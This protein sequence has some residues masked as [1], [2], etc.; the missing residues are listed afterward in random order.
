MNTNAIPFQPDAN[1]NA[2]PVAEPIV[3]PVQV[4]PSSKEWSPT[5]LSVPI[6]RVT[7]DALLLI[8]GTTVG[9]SLGH[10]LQRTQSFE[11]SSERLLIGSL[12]YTGIVL[13]F[14]Q[15]DNAYPRVCSLLHVK[16]TETVLRV[17]IKAIMVGLL[18]CIAARYPVPRMAMLG[19]WVFGT[20]FLAIGRVWVLETVRQRLAPALPQRRSLIYG[21]KRTARRFF[22]GAL[23]SPMLGIDPVGF[24]GSA[25][26]TGETIFS[27]DYFQRDSRP[28]FREPFT[29]EMLRRLEIQDIYVCDSNI[30]DHSLKQIRE[31]AQAANCSLSL[32]DD[33]E[34]LANRTPTRVWEMDGLFVATSEM[35]T[36]GRLYLLIKRLFDFVCSVILIALTAPIGVLLAIAV[37]LESKGPVFFR[38]T[39][40]GQNGKPF[41]ILKFRSMKV[42]APKYARSPDQQSDSRITRVGRLLRKTSLDEM[43]QLINVLKGDMTLVGPR[44]EMPFI[45]EEYGPWEATRLTVPQGITGLWQ[46]SADR[47]FAIHQSI[48][49]D[50]YYIQNRTVLMDIAILLHT[51]VY[52]AKGI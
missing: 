11:L 28:V 52:A 5:L 44:P 50:L 17:S 31:I 35:N 36:P 27:Y 16:E 15:S 2:I 9:A 42:D 51:L 43:P 40:V 45:T 6:L 26:D 47:Q 4:A 29:V 22:T 37:K 18:L 12:I 32:V 21:A 1:E 34:I 41:E 24:V 19:A 3:I 48:E 39:R 23:H 25:N 8:F 38:Q 13:C 14:L 33:Q 20:A 7:T 49:Y 46:L 30:S 10:L